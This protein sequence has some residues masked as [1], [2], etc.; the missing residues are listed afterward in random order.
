VKILPTVKWSQRVTAATV[1]A[2]FFFTTVGEPFAQTSFWADRQAAKTRTTARPLTVSQNPLAS[3]DWPKE[4]LNPLLDG[5]RLSP[6]L[7]SVVE[8]YSSP[9]V[10][11]APPKTV[12]HIQ[13][14]HGVFDAQRNAA[15]ILAGLHSSGWA[16]RA[17]AV[18][19][20]QEGGTG[21]AATDPLS[22]F[23]FADIREEVGRAFL[24]QKEMTGEEYQALSSS[25]GSFRLVGVETPDLYDRNLACRHDTASARATADRHIA[26][27][28][29]GLD[30]I[31]QRT[32][33]PALLTL[34][35]AL[36][37]YESHTIGFDAY[38]FALVKG[39]GLSFREKEYPQLTAFVNLLRTER[40]LDSQALTVERTIM[41]QRLADQLSPEAIRDL[42]DQ[43]AALRAGR[44]T[45]REFYEGLLSVVNTVR[46]KG[47]DVPT[48]QLQRYVNYL[49]QTEA[50]RH[51]LLV[52]ESDKLRDQALETLSGSDRV[53]RL[54]RFDR[55]LALEK[56]LWRQELTP[57]QYAALRQEPPLDWAGFVRFLA[58]EG[59]TAVPKDFAWA[60]ALPHVQAYYE[61]AEKRDQ[62]LSQNALNEMDRAGLKRAVLIAGGF[63]T[64]GMTRLWREQGINYVVIQPRF[65]L[66]ERPPSPGELKI[67]SEMLLARAQVR[68][69]ANFGR[70]AAAAAPNLTGKIAVA[71]AGVGVL[72]ALSAV[73]PGQAQTKQTLIEKLRSFM[74][75][76]NLEIHSVAQIGSSEA[77]SRL[78]IF[79]Q[80]GED[81][82]PFVMV[83][84]EQ[85][86]QFV[87]MDPARLAGDVEYSGALASKLEGLVQGGPSVS[88][89]RFVGSI[90]AMGTRGLTADQQTANLEEAKSVFNQTIGDLAGRI[91]D[92]TAK[93]VKNIDKP[94]FAASKEGEVL[95]DKA[96][97]SVQV[98]TRAA[99]SK[100]KTFFTGFWEKYVNKKNV[101]AG[102][103]LVA[104]SGAAG[105]AESVAIA[106]SGASLLAQIAGIPGVALGAVSA[107]SP[108]LGTFLGLTP[109]LLVMMGLSFV[110]VQSFRRT[111]ALDSAAQA[112]GATPGVVTEAS[113]Q[114]GLLA[115]LAGGAGAAVFFLWLLPVSITF[116]TGVLPTF[117]S[118]FM[119]PV[120]LLLNVS[121]GIGFFM[122][123][124]T[125]AWKIYRSPEY[126]DSKTW[127]VVRVAAP[128]AGLLFTSG[129]LFAALFATAVWSASTSAMVKESKVFGPTVKILERQIV[130][131]LA[132]SAI[133]FDSFR[134]GL[135]PPTNPLTKSVVWS[136]KFIARKTVELGGT[137]KSFAFQSALDLLAIYDGKSTKT[138]NQLTSAERGF[139]T[140]LSLL[141]GTAVPGSARYTF[142]QA[143]GLPALILFYTVDTASRRLSLLVL[144]SLATYTGTQLVGGFVAVAFMGG[145][146]GGLIMGGVFLA[147]AWGFYKKFGQEWVNKRSIE[148]L[149]TRMVL[150][151]AL[152]LASV[153]VGGVAYFGMD[154]TDLLARI[155]SF[156]L[157]DTIPFWDF[158]S[159]ALASAAQANPSK[160]GAQIFHAF[161]QLATPTAWFG[162]LMFGLLLSLKSMSRNVQLKK[163]D[164][165][166]TR[167]GLAARLVGWIRYAPGMARVLWNADLKT[168]RQ[169]SRGAGSTAVGLQFVNPE[170]ALAVGAAS[171]AGG[172]GIGLEPVAEVINK[173]ENT[174]QPS[175]MGLSTQ[176]TESFS[177]ALFGES[178]R[179]NLHDYTVLGTP[180]S[181]GQ[182]AQMG[183]LDRQIAQ[184][185]MEVASLQSASSLK[186]RSSQDIAEARIKLAI[187]E[188]EYKKVA[189][190]SSKVPLSPR[191]QPEK[192]RG[193]LPTVIDLIFPSAHSGE[194]SEPIPSSPDQ[195]PNT[196]VDVPSSVESPNPK[197]VPSSDPSDSVP[198]EKETAGP[199]TSDPPEILNGTLARV[200]TKDGNLNLRAG[201]GIDS[202]QLGSLA[203]GHEVTVLPDV[204]GE[205]I[206][207]WSRVRIVLDGKSVDGFV[208]SRYLTITSPRAGPSGGS[209]APTSET[210]DDPNAASSTPS[211]PLDPTLLT[212][213]DSSNESVPIVISILS[214]LPIL[215]D[216]T[217]ARVA[218]INA[219]KS[220]AYVQEH[221][222][223]YFT[224]DLQL[225]A[226]LVRQHIEIPGEMRD[227]LKLV[228][229][230]TGGGKAYVITGSEMGPGTTKK[231]TGLDAKAGLIMNA[232]I[233]DNVAKKTT[234][235]RERAE[236]IAKIMAEIEIKVAQPQKVV[237]YFADIRVAD[238]VIAITKE[239]LDRL[240]KEEANLDTKFAGN[241]E[242]K[243]R[244]MDE[245]RRLRAEQELLLPKVRKEREAAVKNLFELMPGL[246][247]NNLTIDEIQENTVPDYSDA[248]LKEFINKSGMAKAHELQLEMAQEKVLMLEA[249][250]PAGRNYRL[251]IE[252]LSTIV[253]AKFTGGVGLAISLAARATV[254]DPVREA[255][256]DAGVWAYAQS[257][258]ELA[259]VKQSLE[260]QGAGAMIDAAMQEAVVKLGE[261]TRGEGVSYTNELSKR[262]SQD[263]IPF[264]DYLGNLMSDSNLAVSLARMKRDKARGDVEFAKFSKKDGF[265][266]LRVADPVSMEKRVEEALRGPFS[267]F[268]FDG[269][270]DSLRARLAEHDARYKK[271]IAPVNLGRNPGFKP[272][273]D[274]LLG[275]S[276]G[277]I[278]ADLLREQREAELRTVVGP[279][280]N[281]S[282]YVGPSSE[283]KDVGNTKYLSV[284][285]GVGLSYTFDP[286]KDLR[287][288][289]YMTRVDVATLN[290][291]EVTNKE[292][293]DLGHLL[294]LL[295]NFMKAR[296]FFEQEID[297][298]QE[299]INES[300][301]FEQNYNVNRT[302][303]KNQDR[304]SLAD[305]EGKRIRNEANIKQVQLKIDEIIG[306][307]GRDTISF[308][309][310]FKAHNIHSSLPYL[311]FSNMVDRTEED[312]K[313]TDRLSK[314]GKD[315]LDKT[316]EEIG[317]AR[318]LLDKMK[319][320]IA[321]GKTGKVGS[322]PTVDIQLIAEIEKNLVAFEG[323]LRQATKN[324][325][326]GVN[327][328]KDLN[329]L[330]QRA[331]ALVVLKASL[332]PAVKWQTAEGLGFDKIVGDW[333]KSYR[334]RFDAFSSERIA[335]KTGEGNQLR[336]TIASGIEP[337]TA[338]INFGVLF[339][340]SG[341]GAKIVGGIG[342]PELAARVIEMI[343]SSLV[344]DATAADD[345]SS[346]SILGKII[347]GYQTSQ[348]RASTIRSF[349]MLAERELMIA[350]QKE[351]DVQS[352]RISVI[353]MLRSARD[354]RDTMLLQVMTLEER[355]KKDDPLLAAK[356]AESARRVE[357]IKTKQRLEE[358]LSRVADLEV[359]LLALGMDPSDLPPEIQREE[360]GQIGMSFGGK[361]ASRSFE[362]S[363]AELE[364]KMAREETRATHNAIGV[365]RQPVSVWVDFG[366]GKPR[367]AASFTVISPGTVITPLD[368]LAKTAI[369]QASVDRILD[370]A[371]QQG[372]R[373]QGDLVDLVSGGINLTLSRDIY[374]IG[375]G[376]LKE[377]AAAGR[378]SSEEY[379]A[380][381]RLLIEF[382][383]AVDDGGA[384]VRDAENRIRLA[385]GRPPSEDI[386][387]NY[388]E[389]QASLRS[390]LK[391][392]TGSLNFSL[393]DPRQIV[394]SRIP[395]TGDLATFRFNGGLPESVNGEGIP[396]PKMPETS[397][398]RSLQ[399]IKI[400]EWLRNTVIPTGKL[401]LFTDAIKNGG[402][403]GELDFRW[404]IFGGGGSSRLTI[405]GLEEEK[406]QLEITQKTRN[407]QLALDQNRRNISMEMDRVRIANARILEITEGDFSKLLHK[408]YVNQRILMGDLGA[409]MNEFA[410]LTAERTD[411]YMRIALH[412]Q[413][414]RDILR[415][416]GKDI[417]LLED[418]LDQLGV[419]RLTGQRSLFQEI[420]ENVLTQEPLP[421]IDVP[422][423][424]EWDIAART[425]VRL[426]K[427]ADGRIDQN[428]E[429]TA[430]VYIDVFGERWKAPNTHLKYEGPAWFQAVT[431]GLASDIG[432]KLG[433]QRIL[434][435]N[436]WG[437]F[438]WDLMGDYRMPIT[439]ELMD[440][441]R[442]A[443][444]RVNREFKGYTDAS[445]MPNSFAK[446]TE[447][448]FKQRFPHHAPM[449][450]DY[451]TN[452]RTD[453]NFHSKLGLSLYYATQ[454]SIY[455]QDWLD[456]KFPQDA[457]FIHLMNKERNEGL[458]LTEM[459]KTELLEWK[460]FLSSTMDSVFYRQISDEERESLRRAAQAGLR[461][462][463]PELTR[464]SDRLQRE[465]K[466]GPDGKGGDLRAKGDIARYGDIDLE[467]LYSS[468]MAL[469]I[470][471]GWSAATLT[472][473]FDFLVDHITPQVGRYSRIATIRDHAQQPDADRLRFLLNGYQQRKA[474]SGEKGLG[475][476]ELA[477]F[478]DV[479]DAER[480]RMEVVYLLATSMNKADAY[481]F[482]LHK[483]ADQ[484]LNNSALRHKIT[485]H[486][487]KAMDR[488][489][490]L[491]DMPEIRKLI[492][493][494][495]VPADGR[496]FWTQAEVQGILDA[497]AQ[498]WAASARQANIDGARFGQSDLRNHVQNTLTIL[499]NPAA[500]KAGQKFFQELG[501][502]VPDNDSAREK[503]L[504]ASR[505]ASLVENYLGRPIHSTPGEWT[506][507]EIS[508]AQ[509]VDILNRL[510]STDA[511]IDEIKS[512][513]DL[514]YLLQMA[515][516]ARRKH[517][518]G[519][520][521]RFDHRHRKSADAPTAPELT[522]AYFLESRRQIP[523][524]Y[525]Q[526]V[527]ELFL[528]LTGEN[529]R[530]AG[531]IDWDTLAKGLAAKNK[532][533][534][535]PLAPWETPEQRVRM[536]R[537]LVEGF[538]VK[539]NP[540]DP[541]KIAHQ[542][543]LKDQR[544]S[545]EVAE[546]LA[547]D[548]LPKM[549]M[550]PGDW[551]DRIERGLLWQVQSMALSQDRW[552]APVTMMGQGDL[553]GLIT[554]AEQVEESD[555]KV[556]SLIWVQAE[557][558]RRY[559]EMNAHLIA[560]G[561]PLLPAFDETTVTGLASWILGPLGQ[562]KIKK[563]IDKLEDLSK[564]QELTWVMTTLSNWF[565]LEKK[566]DPFME[567]RL[568]REYGKNKSRLPV[569]WYLDVFFSDAELMEKTIYELKPVSADGYVPPFNLSMYLT[570]AQEKQPFMHWLNRATGYADKLVKE[571]TNDPLFGELRDLQG[572]D[573]VLYRL[574][575]LIAGIIENKVLDAHE[576]EMKAKKLAE[577]RERLLNVYHL[578]KELVSGFLQELSSRLDSLTRGVDRE[579][580]EL[581]DFFESTP[582]YKRFL[583]AAIEKASFN[584]EKAQADIPNRFARSDV[585]AAR[586]KDALQLNANPTIQKERE[587][588]R[589]V[590]TKMGPTAYKAAVIRAAEKRGIFL[591]LAPAEMDL[592]YQ[593]SVAKGYS[594]DDAVE[595]A[596]LQIDAQNRFRKVFKLGDR[597][598]TTVQRGAI[599]GLSNAVFARWG[600]LSRTGSAADL[601]RYKEEVA[602][603][604]KDMDLQLQ[605]AELLDRRINR[606]LFAGN[607]DGQMLL[608]LIMSK[609]MIVV[610]KGVVF[611]GEDNRPNLT[612]VNACFDTFNL[613][614][615]DAKQEGFWP[616]DNKKAARL[617]NSILFQLDQAMDVGIWDPQPRIIRTREEYGD[618]VKKAFEPFRAALGDV[619]SEPRG[620]Q[621]F[622]NSQFSPEAIVRLE[623]QVADILFDRQL[624]PA[625]VAMLIERA[626]TMGEEIK[627]AAQYSKDNIFKDPE[628][629]LIGRAIQQPDPVT[630]LVLADETYPD[631]VFSLDLA[632]I[633]SQLLDETG[634][635]GAASAR[636]KQKAINMM[637]HAS[638]QWAKTLRSAMLQGLRQYLPKYR[639]NTP[640]SPT[641]QV[642]AGAAPVG[643]VDSTPSA[644]APSTSPTEA[645]Q[646][647]TIDK[648][649]GALSWGGMSF[650]VGAFA[651][652]SANK[653]WTK[654][655]IL[656]LLF[657]L[658]MSPLIV[659]AAT[660]VDPSLYAVVLSGVAG[661]FSDTAGLSA[662]L[663]ESVVTNSG[664]ISLMLFA[665]ATLLAIYQGMK[666][667][668]AKLVQ[669]FKTKKATSAASEVIPP[670]PSPSAP[671]EQE[672]PAKK[673]KELYL[674]ILLGALTMAGIF[675]ALAW[676]IPWLE[677]LI[678]L[679]AIQG[680]LNDRFALGAAQ[681]KSFFFENNVIAPHAWLPFMA[682]LSTILGSSLF[683]GWAVSFGLSLLVGLVRGI[684]DRRKAAHETHE[685]SGRASSI[686]GGVTIP[687]PD[688]IN[689]GWAVMS[690]WLLLPVFSAAAFG[691]A[692]A[693]SGPLANLL[694]LT[695]QLSLGVAVVNA[696]RDFARRKKTGNGIQELPWAFVTFRV[697]MFYV[698]FLTFFVVL[699]SVA[700]GDLTYFSI[701]TSVGII[702]IEAYLITGNHLKFVAWLW[703]VQEWFLSFLLGD[704]SLKNNLFANPPQLAKV[705]INENGQGN[706]VGDHYTLFENPLT[707][708][709]EAK[710]RK[711]LAGIRA[712]MIENPSMIA[713]IR[714]VNQD[715]GMNHKKR[716]EK[717][718]QIIWEELFD[719]PD[720]KVGG[721]HSP[722]MEIDNNGEVQ[723]VCRVIIPVREA[724][725]LDKPWSYMLDMA[726]E[727]A[728]STI[729]V[730]E[731]G[732]LYFGTDPS[733]VDD[734]PKFEGINVLDGPT[735]D[736]V[737]NKKVKEA[738]TL[739]GE[740]WED[741]AKIYRGDVPWPITT[742]FLV[743][744]KEG[745]L[746]YSGEGVFD[747]K[748]SWFYG[749][750]KK[751][752]SEE[753]GYRELSKARIRPGIKSVIAYRMVND[754]DIVQPT[755]ELPSIVH[756][757]QMD[758]DH[759]IFQPNV[760]NRGLKS[761]RAIEENDAQFM[762]EH[763]K[764][765][766]GPLL[767]G[768]GRA[769]G[770][771]LIDQEQYNEKMLAPKPGEDMELGAYVG[772]SL[773]GSK[774]IKGADESKWGNGWIVYAQTI[775][776][777]SK[778]TVVMGLSL[779][780]G[781]L[782][783]NF[784]LGTIF[785]IIYYFVILPQ[786]VNLVP[787]SARKLAGMPKLFAS[788]DEA[789]G[790]V[791]AI[792]ILTMNVSLDISR[793]DDAEDKGLFYKWR[794]FFDHFTE[795]PRVSGKVVFPVPARFFNNLVIR[796]NIGAA[797]W[798]TVLALR[799]FATWSPGSYGVM[800]SLPALLLYGYLMFILLQD[801]VTGA[802]LQRLKIL[803]RGGITQAGEDPGQ[804]VKSE[805]GRGLVS[806]IAGLG[807]LTFAFVVMG[808]V[809]GAWTG[810]IIAG[811]AMAIYTLQKILLLSGSDFGKRGW[812][813]SRGPVVGALSWVGAWVVFGMMNWAWTLAVFIIVYLLYSLAAFIFP[814][815]YEKVGRKIR[816]ELDVNERGDGK[817]ATLT[818]EGFLKTRPWNLNM[819]MVSMA[820]P[821]VLL[822]DLLNAILELGNTGVT[823]LSNLVIDLRYPRFG[824]RAV[825]D[826]L[827]KGIAPLWNNQ[828]IDK[829]TSSV[830][831]FFGF[832]RLPMIIF[833]VSW[834]F[835]STNGAFDMMGLPFLSLSQ[836]S[837]FLIGTV[838]A[839][840]FLKQY[841]YTTEPVFAEYKNKKGMENDPYPE[842]YR[843]VVWGIVSLFVFLF[844]S[845]L[846]SEVIPPPALLFGATLILAM[847]I[848]PLVNWFNGRVWPKWLSD[849]SISVTQFLG[850]VLLG[851]S[852]LYYV[853]IEP[854][855]PLVSVFTT[856]FGADW[857]SSGFYF[858]EEIKE[859]LQSFPLFGIAGKRAMIPAQYSLETFSNVLQAFPLI[860]IVHIITINSFILFGVLGL[861]SAAISLGWNSTTLLRRT[862]PKA[863]GTFKALLDKHK[864]SGEVS[865]TKFLEI[866]S[867]V[868]ETLTMPF[869]AQTARLQDVIA[870]DLRKDGKTDAAEKFLTDFN[871][872]RDR[873][874][875]AERQGNPTEEDFKNYY[876]VFQGVLTEDHLRQ[877]AEHI[878][879]RPEYFNVLRQL[880]AL[881]GKPI[882]LRFVVRGIAPQFRALLARPDVA[883]QLNQVGV[884]LSQVEIVGNELLFDK[885]DGIFKQEFGPNMVVNKAERAPKGSIY[886]GDNRDVQYKFLYFVNI[887]DKEVNAREVF[888]K[889]AQAAAAVAK[890]KREVRLTVERA[891]FE[892]SLV[893]IAV[894]V[895][896]GPWISVATALLLG[897]RVFIGWN[898][899]RL[900]VAAKP[901]FDLLNRGEQLGAKNRPS[902]ILLVGN[903]FL[904]S[905][906][907]LAAKWKDGFSNVPI[908]LAG[909][910]GPG[911]PG[912][913]AAVKNKFKTD[914]TKIDET[915]ILEFLNSQSPEIYG[916]LNR[917]SQ[918]LT[919]TDL[920][921]FTLL[922]SGVPSSMILQE[923]IPSGTIQE[924]FQ[925]T[926]EILKALVG[927]NHANVGVVTGAPMRLRTSVVTSELE[928]SL[929]LPYKPVVLNVGALDLSSLSDNEL[930]NLVHAWAGKEGGEV[931]SWVKALS[932]DL[933][934]KESELKDKLDAARTQLMLRL[935]QFESRRSLKSWWG[936]GL[937]LLLAVAALGYSGFSLAGPVVGGVQVTSF[938]LTSIGLWAVGPIGLVILTLYSVYKAYGS[939][940]N[941][942]P[943]SA[944]ISQF[945]HG[946]VAFS[947][948]ISEKIFVKAWVKPALVGLVLVG[949]VVAGSAI[950][951]PVAGGATVA[952]GATAT[953]GTSLAVSRLST[954][955]LPAIFG[956][957]LAAVSV[958][959]STLATPLSP[960]NVL[961]ES[962]RGIFRWG[963]LFDVPLPAVDTPKG[964]ALFVDLRVG[965]Q[966]DSTGNVTVD[967]AVG[968]LFLAQVRS[969]A[970]EFGAAE[971][972]P[973][974]QIELVFNPE[975][976]SLLSDGEP[977]RAFKALLSQAGIS[978]GLAN[979][980][981]FG[982]LVEG[983][984]VAKLAQLA[985]TMHLNVVA[986]AAEGLAFW[987]K[988]G[989]QAGVSLAILLAQLMSDMEV[990][991][992][993]DAAKEMAKQTGIPLNE[994][995]T[996]TI[997]K[998]LSPIEQIGQEGKKLILY[999]QQA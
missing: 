509:V 313:V 969:L 864:I 296:A 688:W 525:D 273:A 836:T 138:Q 336:A 438:L 342:V 866:T 481:F 733:R 488:V 605:T 210:Q 559:E 153:V 586:D 156:N 216:T 214:A 673:M 838:F 158:D 890:A 257:L 646:A 710:Q 72:R 407:H 88:W 182:L 638:D 558:R 952:A 957:G 250:I 497:L 226:S 149:N 329:E 827:L 148:G 450:A 317:A 457:A 341:G 365:P 49:R 816:T 804:G 935:N 435:R 344:P 320:H 57:A 841:Q 724:G 478:K 27:L 299:M 624:P 451:E 164:D 826:L 178:G 362:Y 929:S 328:Y 588:Q 868:E 31:K 963:A 235:V 738:E 913:L 881:S 431:D 59:V 324:A 636:A 821:F 240:K 395:S 10:G 723:E 489:L 939:T 528:A 632:D 464:W 803:L 494:Q 873:Y 656:T 807:T 360:L 756:Q 70:D 846:I 490:A 141:R 350:R 635:E 189:S 78:L 847:G 213:P 930:A 968:A 933:N 371:S 901:Y 850:A 366:N 14:A 777:L 492:L 267:F 129:I 819:F 485:E 676:G 620:T 687:K 990:T 647:T 339:L 81:K 863:V 606:E 775:M 386:K 121:S 547:F 52:T 286:S 776:E 691:A 661:I 369:E 61:L 204:S 793:L 465:G 352:N 842:F 715:I 622:A 634:R 574:A 75:E 99:P 135:S 491:R 958:K 171:F 311:R 878:E 818:Y 152:G 279:N 82:K 30:E 239:T 308:D 883:R 272:L 192:F 392:D 616:K 811:V 283:S 597:P 290:A 353:A 741:F 737:K 263:M 859:I 107:L 6:H 772:L 988:V 950:A 761:L 234:A 857:Y 172:L 717:Y 398:Q 379:N 744:G 623:K 64:P 260:V 983:Q 805:R 895:I 499:D 47:K 163:A 783:Q 800:L 745:G 642:P 53:R 644:P 637:N 251:A 923:S 90:K 86:N 316:E 292:L 190:L 144:S 534:G 802:W 262:Y 504:F 702:L 815:I 475:T 383:K 764:V 693:I 840:I 977:S 532:Q 879:V 657:V 322:Q 50:I 271:A 734:Y 900:E 829:L 131:V 477:I 742:S 948:F 181:S 378:A 380:L 9:S 8:T 469:A 989:Q 752:K 730:D 781:I 202:A 423:T 888:E 232:T 570:L 899:G 677:N 54:V 589:P 443:W 452:L 125:V 747:E 155:F 373:I 986:P 954:V 956:L 484:V 295:E 928:E 414:S 310:D 91:V 755:G 429:R 306:K 962:M 603:D 699:T 20:F 751:K 767:L 931:A 916:N 770:K 542:L 330:S 22:A 201:P 417:P 658:L 199:P 112:G 985:P 830:L 726:A 959:G 357:I 326:A 410:K 526:A 209:S 84:H 67:G 220:H 663:V 217:E 814:V 695:F 385:L 908:V 926:K 113:K 874:L 568:A 629:A 729:W 455:G 194:L 264:R 294:Q 404:N 26:E 731:K 889:W 411:A 965:T 972:K 441:V 944:M 979:R 828:P 335:L 399:N 806:G 886:I 440:N 437:T 334:G 508:A 801:K 765:I 96:M 453:K 788:H 613:F 280:Y 364:R 680:W 652:L 662:A 825:R 766:T 482:A 238:E 406:L 911:T 231:E 915:K 643:P 757:A 554:R 222:A 749:I 302:F 183:Y 877:W 254:S 309:S 580:R 442:L 106:A 195:T 266:V 396:V 354:I 698:N 706:A 506:T 587:A 162:S 521:R 660:V 538:T 692:V 63:H 387:R 884:D 402:T 95:S 445:E 999:N 551:K 434:D 496:I 906:T 579:F 774:P 611:Y 351:T 136:I 287:A 996:L 659:L 32:Y 893:V 759:V 925:N 119:A 891:I 648:G 809:Q 146:V 483:S 791:V 839:L 942:G 869:T 493:R 727:S 418:F 476:E 683:A 300:I 56:L 140:T 38:V 523:L 536:A 571:R 619:K 981:E 470:S 535:H 505:L 855:A 548:T 552:G 607:L 212:V 346:G 291:E 169:F 463:F 585:N 1:A 641:P 851:A 835:L 247:P 97:T 116:A 630:L 519:F 400:G 569:T 426:H 867:D 575:F 696:I 166:G 938:A 808:F 686:E 218:Q 224:V 909:G 427:P 553:E 684:Q 718:S 740:D 922:K 919:D 432:M 625:H 265:E 820:T 896:F 225:A 617:G 550:T 951:A 998:A 461:R 413:T 412:Y 621:R 236:N 549:G 892:T 98:A 573:M 408:D 142:A 758:P 105:A 42:T 858:A 223:K 595:L 681:P 562:E 205:K 852:L 297:V 307:T 174:Q 165:S 678:D 725:R 377:M 736:N 420:S 208:D 428:P 416:Y 708:E 917:D 65:D 600:A 46:Q 45:H 43:A 185:Q 709:G 790:I 252:A 924:N 940:P 301:E 582:V 773:R 318:V 837:F 627:K 36:K 39:A 768:D 541:T 29:S 779:V 992:T 970:Q 518:E 679:P 910:K 261:K 903:P 572:N 593:E 462:M 134:S 487:P 394:L 517:G 871:I 345:D 473:Y 159:H 712:K 980:I 229:I 180:Y 993:G 196:A 982:I 861:L 531:E 376:R 690:F 258:I 150:F 198:T 943:Y 40:D 331:L 545:S 343:F 654:L 471:N 276:Y 419:T 284:Q 15:E 590:I 409:L 347:P 997:P 701:L 259:K 16:G 511:K 315:R 109:V 256:K 321:E 188:E 83:Y 126:K 914:E 333:D 85:G 361:M 720:M 584:V 615:K 769:G 856:F 515:D 382:A 3:I 7:G 145:G 100:I 5:F 368:E 425:P 865:A 649:T 833:L 246:W 555:E 639:P 397:V 421:P 735:L 966:I 961:P 51:A 372:G 670:K 122:V 200:T 778:P 323:A 707:A 17:S 21:L 503:T 697:F 285:A 197:D 24:R 495:T 705:V 834:S 120:F 798:L 813:V 566:N 191:P 456:K 275:R 176:L 177:K 219:L 682:S 245:I 128:V 221:V 789:E 618:A 953:S 898:R 403:I 655:P 862:Y 124:L 193:L 832:F 540:R 577:V 728:I 444:Q 513:G 89:K 824:F 665:G 882:R 599:E 253:G 984:V 713:I 711:I 367:W 215:K 358:I 117:L 207:G 439:P 133:G 28:Q 55:R 920:M 298:F 127:A 529:I 792:R 875:D 486:F 58:E 472:S 206:S 338:N 230:G 288:L 405:I 674:P 242:N 854:V 384:T 123:A 563:V 314:V 289:E 994:D 11:N 466:P 932:R 784:A 601:A 130:G 987:Q 305:S 2:A 516:E 62:A 743:P 995:G 80:Q 118:G 187:L 556:Q 211:D 23:P 363:L 137:F 248:Q 640:V 69:R 530:T 12:F 567:F 714:I 393:H 269:M 732:Q 356:M 479:I 4:T 844:F 454:M 591:D 675:M 281:I 645:P 704:S 748:V 795:H 468:M 502:A 474:G 460:K 44:V 975:Q 810:A 754:I 233:F 945:S 60:A 430:H 581:D 268:F 672:A 794:A 255:L 689:R 746:L 325:A 796:G 186:G 277:V 507:P 594:A 700:A 92:F 375:L 750:D 77:D 319:D 48:H 780:L 608:S 37:K 860:G 609:S 337:L 501:W 35:E 243:K 610:K 762:L 671:T 76:L 848:A 13:D 787:K 510:R 332:S 799:L 184:A 374:R 304:K 973:R 831:D 293:S 626:Q 845:P 480:T 359:R 500:Y 520:A 41:V 822:D 631:S 93:N 401:T 94:L 73:G 537:F 533:L 934:N 132:A 564:R 667:P 244:A 278:G 669:K 498:G 633:L 921:R 971:S 974:V 139:K 327:V 87:V 946:V 355:R 937:L 880:H 870:E 949:A 512:E 147:S 905:V 173:I 653:K 576:I 459:E 967:P 151:L 74:N 991:F 539:V 114:R 370:V 578:G 415:A 241:V 179:I 614:L 936:Q 964:H 282:F 424:P 560:K 340:K 312:G 467:S 544:V 161:A 887:Q 388:E 543:A 228:G 849:R 763:M 18:T 976:H 785:P 115:I 237:N 904:Q 651:F 348:Q 760:M 978:E 448:G 102:A 449:T 753:P 960:L 249:A 270:N 71:L 650:F 947:T 390:V 79:G 897:R 664:T 716:A 111:P 433:G 703:S 786:L 771:F 596:S 25:S 797:L 876:R 167:L 522:D 612:Y 817:T 812:L 160:H 436:D 274:M 823:L 524:L 103:A 446:Y 68:E 583:L 853:W 101:T 203:Q 955:A 602:K 154:Q 447:H 872:A 843:Y 108:V 604:Q 668:W 104:V 666:Q 175:I 722:Y 894:G 227:I 391:L 598:L 66:Q 902:A 918:S 912:L 557:L 157:L 143:M 885:E 168:R 694:L 628:V 19:V 561:L 685:G 565:G 719:H 514:T 907:D 389:A 381:N 33:P 422:I 527:A 349:L 110:M 34:E 782:T 303:Q 721:A 739:E 927:K 941:V 458:P 592:V 170:V 546:A